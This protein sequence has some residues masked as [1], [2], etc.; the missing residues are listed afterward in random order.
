[1]ENTA[2]PK[3]VMISC[4]KWKHQKKESKKEETA[5]TTAAKHQVIGKNQQSMT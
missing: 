2:L 3:Q 5:L 1:M 4:M